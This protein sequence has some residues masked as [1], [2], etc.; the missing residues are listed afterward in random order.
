M[1]I[2]VKDHVWHHKTNEKTV[3]LYYL[4]LQRNTLYFLFQTHMR[5]DMTKNIW[6]QEQEISFKSSYE[7]KVFSF[8]HSA[9]RFLKA[10]HALRHINANSGVDGGRLECG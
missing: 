3:Y 8:S 10:F 9:V 5:L 4:D 1:L 6:E 2:V 7:F